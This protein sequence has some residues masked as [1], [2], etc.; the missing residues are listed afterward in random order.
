MKTYKVISLADLMNK[1]SE[2]SR[3]K[4]TTEVTAPG[5]PYIEN[6]WAFIAKQIASDL[7]KQNKFVL[8][9]IEFVKILES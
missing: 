1:K 9:D 2:I 8:G 6:N 3:K 7:A 5:S 4:I